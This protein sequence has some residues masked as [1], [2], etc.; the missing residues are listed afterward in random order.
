MPDEKPMTEGYAPPTSEELYAEC[1]R[2]AEAGDLTS[3]VANMDRLSR[4][5]FD[6]LLKVAEIRR[7][8]TRIR[9]KSE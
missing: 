1:L 3:T 6:H 4:E 7:E 5:E 9:E 8:A 2:D